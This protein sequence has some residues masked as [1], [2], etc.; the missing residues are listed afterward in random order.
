[1]A[2]ELGTVASGAM[3]GA[4]TGTSINAGWGTA[5]GAVAG[6][7]VG[8]WG[9]HDTEQ[10]RRI[11]KRNVRP[12]F[13]QTSQYEDMLQFYEK[14]AMYGLDPND[15]ALQTD[16]AG[17]GLSSSL[18]TGLQAGGSPN[19]TSELYGNY[20]D[21]IARLSASDSE[22]R[23]NKVNATAAAMK[24]LLDAKTTAFLYNEDAKFKDTAQYAAALGTAGE[25][26]KQAGLDT[27][28]ASLIKGLQTNYGKDNGKT[29]PA[30][31]TPGTP[32][33]PKPTDDMNK[34]RPDNMKN[35]GL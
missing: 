32:F 13:D 25:Q 2:S 9:V 4:I 30:T 17:R 35:I 18:A 19:T 31:T 28:M 1:M 8:L 33:V 14:Q 3:S 5:I 20:S 11:A 27:F 15:I 29:P 21:A 22:M 10:A 34:L 7:L 26:E 24:Q 6:A 12:N 23:W 16:L